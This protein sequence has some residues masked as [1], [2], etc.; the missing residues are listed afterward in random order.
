MDWGLVLASQSITTKIDFDPAARRWYLLVS[1]HDGQ[2][3]FAAIRQYHLENRG[4]R[5]TEPAR[6][7]RE[8][9]NWGALVWAAVLVGIY[10]FTPSG[11]ALRAAGIMDSNAV[12]SGQWWRIFTAMTL[13]EDAEHLAGNLF[14]GTILVGLAMARFGGGTA[15]LAAFLAGACGNVF[16]LAMNQKPF[17][18]LG[19]SGMVMGA[20]GLVVAQAWPR[21]NGKPLRRRFVGVAAGIMLL[22]LYGV[23]PGSDIAAHVGGFVGGLALGTLLLFLPSVALMR[24][25]SFSSVIAL[26]LF[27]A[28]A[29]GM[30]IHNARFR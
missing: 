29:W 4:F 10:W 26:G 1:A 19:A 18:G 5:W 7:S 24:T 30:A 8:S 22:A 11:G 13:H 2:N 21:A 15:L 12:A 6:W 3:A 14:A 9:F 16:S 20:L 23:T 17:D 27:L 28:A 25:V